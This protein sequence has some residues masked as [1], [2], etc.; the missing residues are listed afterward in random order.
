MYVPCPLCASVRVAYFKCMHFS[1][2][3]LNSLQRNGTV[4]FLQSQTE[5]IA[6]EMQPYITILHFFSFLP[7]SIYSLLVHSEHSVTSIL[8]DNIAGN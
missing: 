2:A 4:V 1:F 6:Q 3:G 7:I 8:Y 5:T